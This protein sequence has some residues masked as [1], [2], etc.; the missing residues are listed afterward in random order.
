[1]MVRMVPMTTGGK[2]FTSLPKSGANMKV[3]MP[4]VITAP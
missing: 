4:A 3:A 2:Y 1:M